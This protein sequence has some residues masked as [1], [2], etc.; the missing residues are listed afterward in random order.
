MYVLRF[1]CLLTCME[2][3]TLVYIELSC[4]YKREML[5]REYSTLGM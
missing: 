1:S 5:F 3:M 4:Y 2:V